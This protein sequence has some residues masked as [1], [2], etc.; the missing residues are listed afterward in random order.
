MPLRHN[1]RQRQWLAD[2]LTLQ[3]VRVLALVLVVSIA[4]LGYL[5]QRNAD[6]GG[7]A[8]GAILGKFSITVAIA[9][10]SI[11]IALLIIDSLNQRTAEE[12]VKAKLIRELG[13]S[14]NRIA[15]RAVR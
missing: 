2:W 10:A 6:D 11:A 12:Q 5:I 8:I 13:S 7:P 1:A 15:L 3:K 4:G 14:D 9:L